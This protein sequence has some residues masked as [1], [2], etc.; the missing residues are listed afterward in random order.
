MKKTCFTFDSKEFKEK[1]LISLVKDHLNIL[2]P[3]YGIH[4]FGEIKF[5]KNTFHFYRFTNYSNSVNLDYICLGNSVELN[6]RKN[7]IETRSKPLTLQR[8]YYEQV[9]KFSIYLAEKEIP[10]KVNYKELKKKE[11]KE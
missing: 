8:K 10:F 5:N 9:G 1:K 4:G 6:P 2:L 7:L 11:T 3:G